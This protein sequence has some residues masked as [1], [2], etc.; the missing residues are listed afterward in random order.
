MKAG[1][2]VT[3]AAVALLVLLVCGFATWKLQKEP[4]TSP[5]DIQSNQIDQV[6][7]AQL[8][9][10][11]QE[12]TPH[13]IDASKANGQIL[14]S[15]EQKIKDDL[16][17]VFLATNP[18][19]DKDYYSNV[20]LNAVGKRYSLITQP[21]GGGSYDE[22]IDSKTGKITVVPGEARYYLASEGRD[23]ALYID[24]Q[25]IRTYTLDQADAV[26]VPGSVLSG[27][28]TYH[29]GTSDLSIVPV[30]THT[31]N[32]IT[33]SVFDSSQIVQNPDAQPNAMQTMNKKTR[34]VT[35]PF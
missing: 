19:G 12:I 32:S 34:I 9:A 35:L 33:I 25:A 1:Q 2:K 17:A 7:L 4:T 28:E 11:L 3:I 13:F 14:T 20:W 27:N 30:Q 23:I 15:Q 6:A 26:L 16:V 31:K 18:G 8:Q 29:L 24:N 22:V 10:D 21:S 5:T